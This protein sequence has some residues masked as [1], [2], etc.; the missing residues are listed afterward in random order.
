MSTDTPLPEAVREQIEREAAENEQH[1]IA[2]KYFRSGGKCTCG[3][4]ERVYHAALF[5][6]RFAKIA[7]EAAAQQ[8]RARLRELQ[9][10]LPDAIAAD[11]FSNAGDRADRGWSQR[12]MSDHISDL[13]NAWVASHPP[14]TPEDR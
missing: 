9:D 13:V 11:L 4:A 6:K 3:T 8:E 5:A 1:A 12:A 2:C 14:P 10:E 7:W